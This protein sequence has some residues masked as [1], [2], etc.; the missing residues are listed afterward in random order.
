MKKIINQTGIIIQ[1]V[2][3]W[4]LVTGSTYPVRKELK[5]AGLF[6]AQRKWP[7]TI[8]QR[9]IRPPE[10]KRPLTRSGRSMAV[11]QSTAGDRLKYCNNNRNNLKPTYILQYLVSFFIFGIIL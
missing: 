4:I 5:K 2:G 6:F 8:V 7:G 11:K 3:D 1:I 10:V 9:S